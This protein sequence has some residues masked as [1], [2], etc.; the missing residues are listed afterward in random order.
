MD[1]GTNLEKK[2]GSSFLASRV[3]MWL[4]QKCKFPITSEAEA[5]PAILCPIYR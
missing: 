4:I 1:G 5:Q 2:K 3:K